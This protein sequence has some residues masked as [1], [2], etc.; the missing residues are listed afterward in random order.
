MGADR[1]FEAVQEISLE[2]VVVYRALRDEAGEVADFEY[3]YLNPAALA[4]MM[5]RS[6][7]E[8]IGTRLLERLP[9]AREHPSLYPRYLRVMATG[10]ASQEEYELGGRWFHST[11]ARLGDGIVVTVRDVSASRRNDEIQKLLVQELN[12]R[13][14]NVIAAVIA[15]AGI[16]GREAA[17]DGEFRDKLVARLLAWS[18]AHDL[19][20]ANSW[21][22]AE[23]G[24]LARRVLEP[25]LSKDVGRL[26]IQGPAV[27]VS[28]D[29]ALGLAMALHELATNALK[30]GALSTA[31]GRIAIDWAIEPERR[32]GVRL[33]W[34]ETSPT[35]A[36]RPD[37]AGFG[38]RLLRSAFAAQGGAVD[39]DFLPYGVRCTMR[40]PGEAAGPDEDPGASGI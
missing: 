17:S 33:S 37:S 31:D 19:L 35:P 21:A 26:V 6:A 27:M 29:T 39:L 16:T 32:P 24:Q 9:L 5:R 8:V 14:K 22:G 10:E 20:V 12:H 36:S 3:R 34:S 15:M 7:S 38:T 25:Y 28:A 23:I 40:F 4:I 1:L 30:Y 2:G 11:A 13:V 18:Q